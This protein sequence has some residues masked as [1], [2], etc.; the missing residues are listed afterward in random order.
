MMSET[1]V[2]KMGQA[3]RTRAFPARILGPKYHVADAVCN[4]LGR[5]SATNLSAIELQDSIAEHTVLERRRRSQQLPRCLGIART[6]L[7]KASTMQ[8]W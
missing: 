5:R 7:G 8:L 3:Y 1:N 6:I 2:M 4:F